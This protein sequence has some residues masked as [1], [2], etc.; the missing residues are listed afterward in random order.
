MSDGQTKVAGHQRLHQEGIDAQ[1]TGALRS[2]GM[3]KASA[4]DNW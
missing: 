2:E 4:Q 1:G 3:A